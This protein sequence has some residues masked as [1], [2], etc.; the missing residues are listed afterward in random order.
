MS[1]YTLHLSLSLHPPKKS[2]HL[3]FDYSIL[4]QPTSNFVGFGGGKQRGRY[5]VEFTQRV[6]EGA[7]GWCWRI[8]G[9]GGCMNKNK[10]KFIILLLLEILNF[11]VIKKRD[12]NAIKFNRKF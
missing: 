10:N 2:I 3:S 6:G 7:T 4:Q 11:L 5:K 8:I 12:R 9:V 1:S